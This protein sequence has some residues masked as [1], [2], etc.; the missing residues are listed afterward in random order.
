MADRF[1]KAG[2]SF[3]EYHRFAFDSPRRREKTIFQLIQINVKDPEDYLSFYPKFKTWTFTVGY[4][5]SL[6]ETK[7]AM[8]NCIDK[9]RK[10]GEMVYCFNA[11]EFPIGRISEFDHGGMWRTVIREFLFDEEGELVHGT[12]A[13]GVREDEYTPYGAFIGRP[14]ELMKFKVGD[15]VEVREEG[16]DKVY[17][18]LLSANP[19]SDEK[20]YNEWYLKHSNNNKVRLGYATASDDI[21]WILK[22]ESTDDW[23]SVPLCTVMKARFPIPDWVRKRFEYYREL[24]RREEQDW[25]KRDELSKI[26]SE[27]MKGNLFRELY[28]FG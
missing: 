9:S 20:C 26:H 8:Q 1:L 21:F 24:D 17:L 6:N 10:R 7:K 4:F 16:E 15:Y 19:V 5:S 11:K 18:A 12:L 22:G 13:S 2:Q 3:E 14:K 23:D 27:K 28:Q 25:Q